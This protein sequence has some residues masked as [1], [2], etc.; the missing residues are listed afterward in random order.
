MQRTI[1]M[2]RLFGLIGYPL[3]HSFS[4]RYFS[5]KFEKEGL[6]DCAYELFPIESI[7]QLPALLQQYPELTGLNVTIPYK[8]AVM[9]YLHRLNPEAAA[10]GAVNTI[11]IANGMLTGYNTDAHGFRISLERFLKSNQ[12]L[13]SGALVLGTGG[14]SKAVTWV[15]HQMQIPFILVSRHPKPGQI[16]YQDIQKEL[17]Q[18]YPLVVNATPLGM[19]PKVQECPPLPY[20]LL[21]PN[22]LLYDLVYNPEYTRFLQQGMEMGCYT[23]NGLE[24]LYL[25][26]EKAWALW[27]ACA[28]TEYKPKP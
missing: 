19:A 22:N 2:A 20:H 16:H 28:T 18:Q 12:K 10:I 4:K 3:T 26:A 7:D 9:P 23:S 21:T 8:E 24:M 11:C 14:A 1:Y 5:E 27:N 6:T 15:L 13:I 17:L 25:Q